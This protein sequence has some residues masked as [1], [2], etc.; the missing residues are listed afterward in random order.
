[1]TREVIYTTLL[2]RKYNGAERTVDVRISKLRE[3]LVKEGMTRVSI[4]TVW[5][6]GYTLSES[7]A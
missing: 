1:M 7:A 2:N 5:G 4:D 3:K 6:K